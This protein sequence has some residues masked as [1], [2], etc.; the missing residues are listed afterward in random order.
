MRSKAIEMTSAVAGIAIV[1]VLAL[2]HL[3]AQSERERAS[4]PV[5]TH[6]S[7]TVVELPA[8][9]PAGS[10]VPGPW[11]G[12]AGKAVAERPDAVAG[13][14][15]VTARREW[16]AASAELARVETELE[17]VDVRFD[18]VEAEFL[19]REASGEEDPE[20]LDQEL[21]ARLKE[22]V[23]AYSE[24]ERELVALESAEQAAAARLEAAEAARGAH[25]G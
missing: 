16:E 12:M 23:A 6:T 10:A 24:L 11:Q 20:A 9:E 15:P 4:E 13:S 14:D 25:S 7:T 21:R 18:A 3:N 2:H 8:L 22:L 5:V 1:G 17:Q 19:R